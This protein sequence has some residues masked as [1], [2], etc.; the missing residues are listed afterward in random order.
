VQTQHP[1][2]LSRNPLVVGGDEGGA[3]FVADE[4]EELG[5]DE[6]GGGLVEIAGGRR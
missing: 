2:H 3:A 1:I 5:E 4:A 6:V